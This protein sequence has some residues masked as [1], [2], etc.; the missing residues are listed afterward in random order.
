MVSC[1]Q[2]TLSDPRLQAVV[3]EMWYRHLARYKNSLNDVLNSLREAG[4]SGPYWY[5]QDGREVI[6]PEQPG[7]GKFNKISIRDVDFAST[8]LKSTKCYEVHGVIV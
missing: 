4:L 5:D 8:R 2:A 3:I 6:R 7:K 1:A